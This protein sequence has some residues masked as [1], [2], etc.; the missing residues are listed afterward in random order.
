LVLQSFIDSWV[1]VD[2]DELL[3]QDRD[4]RKQKERQIDDKSYTELLEGLRGKEVET[5]KPRPDGIHS[6][7]I[8]AA[9]PRVPPSRRCTECYE[10]RVSGKRFC[11][12][13]LAEHMEKPLNERMGKDG[14]AFLVITVIAVMV[15]VP[16]MIV[17]YQP[18]NNEWD[19]G[20]GD[21]DD[22]CQVSVYNSHEGG[23]IY[24]YQSGILVHSGY[25]A[26]RDTYTTTFYITRTVLFEVEHENHGFTDSAYGGIG[27]R[28]S[29]TA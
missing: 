21:T 14:V 2:Y 8:A 18:P 20:N 6:K 23:N 17:F 29:L 22:I 28:I 13:H 12:H 16:A 7:T 10:P 4:N 24:I 1:F 9:S 19:G 26:G 3:R 11:E 15:L 27:G 25:L 5:P